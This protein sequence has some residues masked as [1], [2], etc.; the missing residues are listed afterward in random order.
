MYG[1]PL[2]REGKSQVRPV[3]LEVVFS[4][5]YVLAGDVQPV[6]TDGVE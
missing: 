1:L 6:R 2:R 4:A 5:P 3:S